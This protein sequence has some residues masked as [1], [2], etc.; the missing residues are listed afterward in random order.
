MDTYA[1]LP[2]ELVK[3]RGV[4]VRDR[5]GR[6]YLDCVAGIATCTLGHSDGVMRRALSKQLGRLQ[7]VSNLYRIPEQ[8]ELARWIV[9]RSCA[10][11]VFFC[12]SGAEANEAAIKLARKHGHQ[13]R[14]IERPLIL[15]AQASFHGRT[16][17][18]VSATGQPKYHQGFEPMV[19]GF[20]FFPYNDTSAFEALLSRSEADGP[21]VAAVMLEP[22]Q[23]EGGVNPGDP[24]FF[25]R[26]RQLCDQHRILLIFDEVQIGMGRSGCLWGYEKLGVEPDAFTTAKG[27]GGG[28]PIGALAVKQAFDHFRPG[29]HAST[30]GGNPLA[31]RAA[32]TV[33]QELERRLLVPHVQRMGE[34]LQQ[35][36]AEL[37]S[38]HPQLLEGVRGWGLL[39]GLVLRP[40]AP[41]APQIV[42]SAIEKGLL[43]VPAGPRVVRLVPPLV[44]K[45][46][47]L[48]QAVALLEHSLLALSQNI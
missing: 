20:H 28:F 32:L 18:T 12:N 44:I 37:V 11:R 47:Q 30:F 46:R 33:A 10:D 2:L 36:L 48:R 15:T 3:G 26:V 35:L 1:R 16:L 29:D 21:R 4:W 14:G 17:A 42:L 7:H 27:L 8:E 38:R 41:T 23:G 43:V 45:P 5:Q 25:Q 31:C 34:L 19:E 22:L 39:Q 40:E 6:R 24:A 13:V 9:G